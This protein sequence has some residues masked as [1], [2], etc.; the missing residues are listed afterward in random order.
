MNTMEFVFDKDTFLHKLGEWQNLD[1]LKRYI[2]TGDTIG[3][4]AECHRILKE[5]AMDALFP[6]GLRK[7]N[8]TIGDT[9]RVIKSWD[10]DD[11]HDSFAPTNL[12][13]MIGKKYTIE[14]VDN[15]G[16]IPK[17]KI[18]YGAEI[19]QIYQDCLEGTYPDEG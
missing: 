6:C 14:D 17:Y 16:P 5:A 4:A 2:F 11:L 8:F 19:M 10:R 1:R 13:E 9:V 18:L 7:P 3:N 12:K 15:S